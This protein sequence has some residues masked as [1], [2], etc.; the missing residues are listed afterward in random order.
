VVH[1]EIQELVPSRFK[2][3]K[4]KWYI[5]K[6]RKYRSWFKWFIRANGLNG[7]GTSSS[8]NTGVSGSK[9]FIRKYRS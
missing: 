8:G 4:V 9:W 6:F 2:W 3:I 5:R 1:Q 7:A